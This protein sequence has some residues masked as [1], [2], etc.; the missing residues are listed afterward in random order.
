MICET[1]EELT[2]IIGTR[3]ACR[4]VGASVASV[5]R[6][7]RPPAAARF[8]RSWWPSSA[9][10]AR[11]RGAQRPARRQRA[12]QRLDVRDRHVDHRCGGRSSVGIALLDSSS[13]KS[14]ETFP[15]TSITRR[16][17]SRSACERLRSRRSRTFSTASGLGPRGPRGF[18]SSAPSAPWSRCSRHFP[19]CELYNPSRRSSAPISPGFEHASASRTIDNLYAAV[20]RRREPRSTSSG[21]GTPS[22]KARPPDEKPSSPTAPCVPRPAASSSDPVSILEENCDTTTHPFSPSGSVIQQRRLSHTS[23]AERGRRSCARK[24]RRWSRRCFAA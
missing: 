23:L 8:P 21:S 10:H 13:S 4:A 18:G 2:P 22:G 12:D 11:A 14:A 1:V 6:H 7:R 3:P 5:Y 9:V 15:C 17:V 19:R 24:R 20:N 16:A